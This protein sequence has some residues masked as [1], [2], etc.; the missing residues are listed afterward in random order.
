[1]A[2]YGQKR[3]FRL[4]SEIPL[5]QGSAA[6]GDRCCRLKAR[7]LLKPVILNHTYHSHKRIFSS[8]FLIPAAK[9]FSC[10]GLAAGTGE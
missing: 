8:G 2:A 6:S 9:A 10:R 1:M 7:V 3:P 5:C 4:T